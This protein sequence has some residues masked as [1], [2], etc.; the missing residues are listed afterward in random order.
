M[1]R[2]IILTAMLAAVL[3]L[4]SD[5][6]S[7]EAVPKKPESS[8]LR[9]ARD[10][11]HEFTVTSSAKE[12]DPTIE[13]LPNPLLTYDDATRNNEAGTLWA[14]GKAGRPVAF[15]EL[16]RNVGKDQPWVHAFTLTSPE[17]IQL[18]GPTERR[19]TPQSSH[20][21]LRD[22]PDSPDVGD[23][24]AVRLR[25]MKEISRRFEAHEFWDP[26]N[27]RFEMRLLVQP[28]HR[29]QDESIKLTDGAVFVLAHGTNPEVLIQIEAHADEQPPH[30]RYSLVRLGSAELHV[31]IDGKEVWKQ[32]RTPGIVGQPVDPYWLLITPPTLTN[33]K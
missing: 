33:S 4:P 27:S 16:Y 12:H 18:T 7:D 25:Q 15:L 5:G 20:F 30:W 21:A 14:W 2:T 6:L 17:L 28:V 23:K 24:P 8:A 1:L 26:N 11:M 3:T 32:D 9:E 29:Y 10:H 19:W 22:F 13:L 31:S